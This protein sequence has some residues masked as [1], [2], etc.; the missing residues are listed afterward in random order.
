[1]QMTCTVFKK[2][3]YF[4]AK[5]LARYRT[6]II[7]K[8]LVPYRPDRTYKFSSRT[9][10]TVRYGTGGIGIRVPTLVS[11]THIPFLPKISS[12]LKFFFKN[13]KVPGLKMSKN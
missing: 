11:V 7:F 8:N 5:K 13:L 10:P 6:E 2:K 12:D 3:D 4:F 9:R 1:M